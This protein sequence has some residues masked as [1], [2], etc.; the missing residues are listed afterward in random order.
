MRPLAVSLLLAACARA[1][2]EPSWRPDLVCPGD[3][4]CP[5]ADG[6]LRVGAAARSIVPTC[7]ERWDDLDDNNV[8]NATRDALHD[9]GCDRLCPGDP[10]YPGPDRGEGDG[11]IQTAWLAGFQPGRAMSGVR[12]ATRGLVGEGD[13][14]DARAVVFVRGEASVAILTLDVIGLFYEPDVTR[15][16]EAVGALGVDIDHVV[17][18]AS[19]NHEG[20]DTMGNWGSAF[21]RRGV[22]DAY[23]EEM[24]A[25]AAA[26]V[27]EAA[28]NARPVGR[29]RVGEGDAAA[30]HPERGSRNLVNDTRDPYIVDSRVGVAHFEAEDGAPLATL[31][32][33]ANHPETM[34][35]R[36][37]LITSDY[38]H[39]LRRGV[40]RGVTW[41][42]RQ[43]EGLGGTAI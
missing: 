16:R 9:C 5:T 14:I 19:H 22:D 39:A 27:A 17:V 1:P 20:P 13:G 33:W 10:G 12:D 34:G 41:R 2:E 26:V 4:A 31:I 28:G 40:E 29:F 15:I 36:N 8:F 35:A 11:R 30:W 38:V 3:P 21:L 37:N 43:A 24:I 25:T 6:P 23:R 18:H 7:W 42:A 32:A